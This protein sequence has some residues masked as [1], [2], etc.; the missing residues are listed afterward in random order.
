MNALLPGKKRFT[1]KDEHGA[2]VVDFTGESIEWTANV[3]CEPCNNGWM[4]KIENE[5]A[6]PSLADLI[7]G[8]LD[9]PISQ[10]R[11]HSI[12]LFAFKTAVVF[13]HLTRNR[14][15]FFE[16]SV[17][18]EFRNSLAIP[19][20]VSMWLAGFLPAGKGNAHTGYHAG[21]F[22]ETNDISM[23]VCTY[24]VGH[25]V[26]QI[27]GGNAPR[28]SQIRTKTKEFDSIS[29]PIWPIVLEGFVWP[30]G[31]VLRTVD[32][33]DSYSMRWKDLEVTI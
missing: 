22:R 29:V 5:H 18:H 16:R 2:V 27:V 31:S 19:P 7:V 8:K 28:V 15:P 14:E 21:S 4:S 12:A 1:I 30:V 26:I 6:K 32:D 17:R 25:V 23:Y 33:F 20:N 3:V 10:S 9:I 11:A 24:A 13:D